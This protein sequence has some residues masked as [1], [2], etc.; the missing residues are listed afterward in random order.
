MTSIF[1]TGGGGFV[2][3]H[4]I[5]SL[6]NHEIFV[7]LRGSSDRRPDEYKINCKVLQYELSDA[8][9]ID[10]MSTKIDTVI[11]LAGA[12]TTRTAMD[13]V[14]ANVVTTNNV[15]N[16]MTKLNIPNIVFLSTAAVWSGTTGTQIDEQT[17]PAPNTP[18]GFAK[19]AAEGL[20][21]DA[22]AQGRIET[23]TILRCNNTYGIGSRQ[24]VVANFLKCVQADKAV[25][26]DGD[27]MQLR[28]PLYV[29]DLVNLLIKAS[30]NPCGLQVY[31]VSGPQAL[32]VYEI[33]RLIAEVTERELKINWLPERTDRSRHLLI[34]TNKVEV[35]LGWKPSTLLRDGLKAMLSGIKIT[36]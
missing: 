18:Y 20:L 28:E 32:S 12:V 10:G 31:G 34:S 21:I 16:I 7:Q 22:V 36:R 23:A 4:L 13:L 33:A 30:A 9:L 2:A 29:M 24:G 35:G 15:I 11:H 17:L 27:G 5:R 14:I 1:I 3:P 26:I 8:A 6:N 25:Q 19:L